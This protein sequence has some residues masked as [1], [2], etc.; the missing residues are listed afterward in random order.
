MLSCKVKASQVT[1]LTD[2]RYYAAWEVDWMGFCLDPG[3]ES[4]ISR[5]TFHAIREWV[6][7]P[8]IV[9][10]FF[11]LPADDILSVLPDLSVDAIQLGPFYSLA[12]A[13]QL[14][15]KPLIKLIVIAPDH[16]L[17]DI[18]ELLTTHQGLV[19]TFVLDFSR[20]G[21]SWKGLED[22]PEFDHNTLLSL[23]SQF[24]ILLSIDLP[25]DELQEMLRSTK[26]YGINLYGSEEE[27][28]GV[29]SFEEI[30]ELIEVLY[31][32]E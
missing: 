29:K 3:H 24:P 22:H 17:D 15:E 9:A 23:C 2:A 31:I 10:E 32:E 28:V 1:N 12:D 21:F 27:A 7:G 26:A 25:P 5:A 18:E 13:Q 14:N 30:D 19:E 4:A 6:E 20:N 16:S 8:Y 11:S